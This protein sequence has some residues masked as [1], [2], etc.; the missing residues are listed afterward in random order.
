MGQNGRDWLGG[1]WD[2]G[3]WAPV[4]CGTPFS[5]V[6]RPFAQVS[7]KPWPVGHRPAGS[8]GGR[9]EWRNPLVRKQ[10]LGR[11]GR[12]G[13]DWLG[14][15]WDRGPWAPVPCGTPFSAILRPFAQVSPKPWPVGHRP[16]GSVDGRGEWRNPPVRKQ[17]LGRMGWRSRL[18]LR[19]A[20]DARQRDP[21]PCGT[22]FLAILRPFAQVSPKPWPVGHR[23]GFRRW[24]GGAGRNGIRG[25][26]C[27]GCEQ[28][29]PD[30]QG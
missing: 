14:G 13:R 26:R 10:Q 27:L 12:N 29:R 16:A 25:H 6:L 9:G 5:A 7:P 8:V 23:G 1:K 17:Q 15:K 30:E 24:A 18:W 20:R 22:P 21:V 28:G 4:P 2:R 11:M 19:D 3:P